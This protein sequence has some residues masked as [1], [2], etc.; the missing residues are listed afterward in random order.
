MAP[1]ASAA[2]PSVLADLSRFGPQFQ[3]PAPTPAEAQAYCRRLAETHYENFSV[4]SWLTPSSLRPHLANIYAF[5]RWADD[6]A[7][8]T[9][10]PQ[11]SLALLD[12]WRGELDHC[13][14][15]RATHPVF[16]ALRET[17]AAHPLPLQPFLDLISAFRQDQS[18]RSYADFSSL[19]DYCRRSA[20]PV[21]RIV[22]GLLGRSDAQLV[23]WADDICTGLQLANF[24]QDVG[25]DFALGRVYLPEEDL[26]RFQISLPDLA[27]RPSTSAF[28]QLLEFEVDRARQFLNAGAR[29][30]F[31]FTG[32]VRLLLDLF[33]RGGL[34]I[35]QEIESIG[36][37]VWEQRPEVSSSAR[38]RLIGSSVLRMVCPPWSTMAPQGG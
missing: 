14:A 38:R 28:R 2:A 3:G 25:R 30:P 36:Y 7:D 9:G 31:A 10:D 27:G 17:R 11:Q 6:L 19:H 16:V 32:R 37:R 1:P 4:L 35:C 29:L 23:G 22:L 12:W 34:R 8:E 21:G 33:V 26:A 13:F 24:W 20:N 15:G 5:C 18:V